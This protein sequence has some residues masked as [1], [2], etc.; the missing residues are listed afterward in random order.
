[1]DDVP[2]WLSIVLYAVGAIASVAVLYL[3]MLTAMRHALR[4]PLAEL[5]KARRRQ[6]DLLREISTSATYVADVAD[7][8]AEAEADRRSALPAE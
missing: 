6:E 2:T 8:W 3:L 1:M 4:E 7:V 5:R